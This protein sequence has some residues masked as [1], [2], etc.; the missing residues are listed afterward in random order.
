MKRSKVLPLLL[1]LLALVSLAFISFTLLSTQT[2]QVER[3]Q[4][5]VTKSS[6][7]AEKPPSSYQVSEEEKANLASQFASLQAINPETIAYIYAPGTMLD[8]PVVQTGDNATYLSKTFDGG[9]DPYMGTVFMDMDNRSDFSDQL[10]WLFGHARGTAVPDHRM[11]NDVNFYDNQEYF[12]QHPYIVIQT[13][14]RIYYYQAAFLIIVP[15]T[16]AF[17]RTSF[18]DD[19]QFVTQ[20]AMVSRDAVTRNPSITIQSTDRYIVLSTCREEDVTIRANLYC[21]Q[22]PDSEMVEFLKNH[23]SELVYQAT[24]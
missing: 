1:G 4:S 24:R 12:D 15:E 22:I 2:S 9:Y 3:T 5:S 8:E 6:S 11:F 19:K 21:R 7:Q 10:T 20:L 18:E 17:Y 16:T 13:P 23:Q 14:E